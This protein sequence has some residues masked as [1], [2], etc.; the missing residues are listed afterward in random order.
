VLLSSK[1]AL[2]N[3]PNERVEF[4]DIIFDPVDIIIIK[5]ISEGKT[6][7]DIASL[8]CYSEGTIKNRVSKILSMTGLSDRTEISVFAIKNQ[9]I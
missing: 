9:I 2:A 4:G 3:T 7:K 6:N 8:L 5:Q 1:R